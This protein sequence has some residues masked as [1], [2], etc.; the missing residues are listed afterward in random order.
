MDKKEKELFE[1]I[2]RLREENKRLRSEKDKRINEYNYYNHTGRGT[3][4]C[5][6]EYKY[7]NET[8]HEWAT[9]LVNPSDRYSSRCKKCGSRE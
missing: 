7:F 3:V 6:H 2:D 8:R 4:P 1:E 9:G 5:F